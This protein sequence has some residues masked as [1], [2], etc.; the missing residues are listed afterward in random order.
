MNLTSSIESAVPTSSTTG[1]S[2][3]PGCATAAA[4]PLGTFAEIC[5]AQAD[6][7]AQSPATPVA[8]PDS[9][10]S[11][12]SAVSLAAPKTPSGR[13][14]KNTVPTLADFSSFVLLPGPS[15]VLPLPAPEVIVPAE[16]P[17]AS[18]ISQSSGA[19]P[20]QSASDDLCE[21]PTCPQFAA[22]GA[23]DLA[24]TGASAELPAFASLSGEVASSVPSGPVL[25]DPPAQPLQSAD[26]LPALQPA[27]MQPAADFLSGFAVA[28]KSRELSSSNLPEV[29]AS[30]AA[31]RVVTTGS[32]WNRATATPAS[33]A[34]ASTAGAS[35]T[36]PATSASFSIPSDPA[37]PNSA[38]QNSVVMGA[39][40]GKFSSG[41]GAKRDSEPSSP[42][43]ETSA[44]ASAEAAAVPSNGS[45]T[46]FESAP[47]RDVHSHTDTNERDAR[48]R[49]PRG[50]Q[51]SLETLADFAMSEMRTVF[52]VE[53]ASHPGENTRP[54]V[55]ASAAPTAGIVSPQ[56]SIADAGVI[57]TVVPVLSA[58]ADPA[59]TPSVSSSPT[60]P[61]VTPAQAPTPDSG[62]ETAAGKALAHPVE[63]LFGSSQHKDPPAVD[64]GSNNVSQPVFVPPAAVAFDPMHRASTTQEQPPLTSTL[65]G[66]DSGDSTGLPHLAAE[67]R[68]TTNPGVGPVQLAQIA[69][70]AGQAEM[71]IGLNTSAFGSVEVRTIVH[72]SDVGVVIGSEKGDL[73]ALLTNDLPGIAHTLQQQN[74]RLAQV[75]FQQQGF[76][77]SSDASSGGNAQPRWFPP[78]AN[79]SPSPATETSGAETETTVE[80]S[81]PRR[82]GLSILV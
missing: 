11:T 72:A 41:D 18:G 53:T 46:D 65:K 61:S 1:S 52:G 54:T 63:K 33:A 19:V 13:S 44:K 45:A 40:P 34:I 79:H 75:S 39:S 10:N 66:G 32:D 16:D 21:V 37:K 71:R 7:L 77:F 43:A 68:P 25:Q 80:S 64:T 56:P 74:L 5:Q 48:R 69:S 35:P 28:D 31:S 3:F 62:A 12:P 50:M 24:A 38:S 17:R 51:S 9:F 59:T 4:F 30:P 6:T 2:G 14:A 22:S 78:K 36:T 42:A 70:K 15:P 82:V 49:E 55:T 20:S 58:S 81:R 8:S 73:H 57:S 60:S 76:T 47:V 29:S 67:V 23:A 27:P 26:A